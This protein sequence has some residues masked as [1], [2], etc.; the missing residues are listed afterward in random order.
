MRADSDDTRAL[1]IAVAHVRLDKAEI[2]LDAACF[3]RGWH[4]LE[5]DWR[6]TNGDARIAALGARELAFDV[7]MS[8]LYWWDGEKDEVRVA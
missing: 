2:G 4:A 1:G 3:T 5:Q 8:G 7:T 6:W